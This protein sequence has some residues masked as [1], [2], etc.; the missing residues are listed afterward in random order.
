MSRNSKE[1][2]LE[3][4]ITRFPGYGD[5]VGSGVEFA[6]N[7]WTGGELVTDPTLVNKSLKPRRMYYSPIGDG[8][9]AAD[10]VEMKRLPRDTTPRVSVTHQRIVEKGDPGRDGVRI[11]EKQW[12]TGGDGG[13]LHGGSRAGSEFGGGFP[14][15]GRD[16]RATNVASPLGSLADP[17]AYANNLGGQPP[18]G[19]G[20]SGY[21][22]APS[23]LNS[24]PLGDVYRTPNANPSDK[25][26]TLGSRDPYSTL[27]STRSEPPKNDYLNGL[28]PDS[29]Y[30]SINDFGGP[31][32]GRTST[33][34]A[35]LS[36]P[37]MRYEM[38][39]DYKISNPKELIHQY[40]TQTPIQTIDGFEQLPDAGVTRTVKSS[41]HKTTTEET[42]SPYPPYHTHSGADVPNP[43]KFVRQIRDEGLTPRQHQANQNVGP[44]VQGDVFTDRKVQEI[45]QQTQTRNRHVPDVDDLTSRLMQGLQTGHPTPPKY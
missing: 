10:G 29:R 20:T 7:F 2:S 5:R 3:R 18:A 16:S 30:G 35:L 9:V 4:D 1:R 40:A 19:P 38:K 42:Y 8:V 27:G 28:G 14:E 11:V 26:G 25:Y 39:K 45:R 24:T 33:T 43:L 32:S 34:S 31:Q 44:L 37:G 15:S 6:P 12:T 22:T 36:E 13:S 17:M 21:G 41:Y 23:R